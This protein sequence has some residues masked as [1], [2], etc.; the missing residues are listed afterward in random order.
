MTR[1]H[2]PLKINSIKIKSLLRDLERKQI[3]LAAEIDY[4]PE[5]LSRALRYGV[6]E[7]NHI[8]DKIAKYLDVNPAYLTDE[9]D[10]PLPY[11]TPS[12][13]DQT[14]L[15]MIRNVKNI[16]ININ[17]YLNEIVNQAIE[18]CPENKRIDQYIKKHIKYIK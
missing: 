13:L 3:D 15:H 5:G 6:I 17:N 14:Q 8:L 11:P 16:N 7:N 18:E 2:I 12:G 9:I 10:I 1:N 4:T